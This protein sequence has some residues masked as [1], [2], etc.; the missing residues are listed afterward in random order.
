MRP[1]IM[2]MILIVIPVGIIPI[3]AG[4]FGSDYPFILYPLGFIAGTL[5]GFCVGKGWI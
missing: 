2:R 5:M 3:F 1:M 4:L